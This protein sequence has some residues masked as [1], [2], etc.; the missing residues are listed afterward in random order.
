M[1]ILHCLG[2]EF[3][4]LLKSQ[5]T[6][7]MFTWTPEVCRIIAFWAVVEGERPLFYIL[8]GFR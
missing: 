7:L 1:D 8:L 5:E 2:T 3:V 4:F 6:L